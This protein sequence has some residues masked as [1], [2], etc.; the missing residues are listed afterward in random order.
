MDGVVDVESVVKEQSNKPVEGELKA[1]LAERDVAC[2]GCGYSLR[3]LSQSACPE[4]NHELELGVRL[5]EPKHGPYITMVVTWA[6]VWGFHLLLGIIFVLKNW[7]QNERELLITAYLSGT[8]VFFGIIVYL[9]VKR[10]RR[11]AKWSSRVRL[12]VAVASVLLAVLAVF[13]SFV[14]LDSM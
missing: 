3:G 9:V 2:P 7:P 14:V 11:M 1:F 10:R 8:A 12:L 6:C 5:V 13:I 4:C